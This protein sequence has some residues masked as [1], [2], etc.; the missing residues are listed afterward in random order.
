MEREYPFSS[1]NI[2]MTYKDPSSLTVRSC[3]V[4][5][6]QALQVIQSA[7]VIYL[8]DLQ[9]AET[10]INGNYGLPQFH[11]FLKSVSSRINLPCF[12]L[13][14]WVRKEIEK[15]QDPND[16]SK[17]N[18]GR[19]RQII[20]WHHWALADDLCQ[21]VN[22]CLGILIGK[23]RRVNPELGKSLFH[24]GNQFLFDRLPDFYLSRNIQRP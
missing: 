7:C 20:L 15:K 19:S 16:K 14:D 4:K 11:T 12:E 18:L 2:D 13:V 9:N 3:V 24:F 5:L 10:F 22:I 6:R 23:A 1:L 8:F 21:I 17:Y